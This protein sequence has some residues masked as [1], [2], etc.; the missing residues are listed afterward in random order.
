MPIYEYKCSKCEHEFEKMCKVN[1]D[2]ETVCP[3]CGNETVTKVISLNSFR[4]K[5]GGWYKD[6]Y[7]NAKP[8]D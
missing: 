5:G 6:G 4:L 3:S 1:E 2:N 8:K 7:S